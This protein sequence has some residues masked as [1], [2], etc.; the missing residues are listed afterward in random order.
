MKDDQTKSQ[1]I[2]CCPVCNKSEWR[3][4]QKVRLS[5]LS[6]CV[7]CGLLATTAFLIQDNAS[8]VCYD[9]TPEQYAQYR[10]DYLESRLLSYGREMAKIERF[11]QYNRLLE[12]GSGYGFFL[13]LATRAGWDSVGVEISKYACK[14][15][16]SHGCKVYNCDL[17]DVSFA[18][19]FFDVIVMWD[20]IEHIADPAAIANQCL[21]LL[22]PGGALLLKTP[23]A[24]AL[25]ASFGP[26]RTMY[27][28]FVYP[29]NTAE[30]I[31]H[32]TPTHLSAMVKRIGFSNTEVALN[33]QWD[34]RI[35][36]GNNLLVRSIRL[37]IMRYAHARRLPYEFILIGIK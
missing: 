24:R 33:E 37:A 21:N 14:I 23:D 11:R 7:N 2:I 31:F 36:T 28:H 8:N 10:K 17:K 26:I 19:E 4:T 13:E 5:D 30:H 9:V 18:S 1:S 34:E 6:A 16:E 35:V 3:K 25:R 27:R 32:F 12:V 22:R 29:A 20:V 15:A